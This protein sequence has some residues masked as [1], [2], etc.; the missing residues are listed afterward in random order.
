MTDDRYAA[1]AVETPEYEPAG[2][3]GIEYEPGSTPLEMPE[4]ET[5]SDPSPDVGRPIDGGGGYGGEPGGERI[6]PG[7]AIPNPD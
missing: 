6:R 4:T 5:P 2:D 3:P 1:S 7:F